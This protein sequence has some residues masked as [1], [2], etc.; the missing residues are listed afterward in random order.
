MPTLYL[1]YDNHFLYTQQKLYVRNTPRKEGWEPSRRRMT[2]R[3]KRVS[4]FPLGGGRLIF[5][6]FSLSGRRSCTN[7]M[8]EL[9][10]HGQLVALQEVLACT[11][12]TCT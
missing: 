9:G 7:K 1:Q 3:E 4:R 8:P 6:G 11:H 12:S 5:V 10:I 2:G